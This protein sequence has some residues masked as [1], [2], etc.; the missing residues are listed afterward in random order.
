M[1]KQIILFFFLTMCGF[2][3]SYS[4]TISDS[5]SAEPQ[6]SFSISGNVDMYYRYGKNKT[7]SKTIPSY[8][9]G[10]NLGW[11]N[12]T[13]NKKWK[14]VDLVVD[15]VAGPRADQFYKKEDQE[16]V[17]T[18]IKQGYISYEPIKKL[19]LY[20]GSMTTPFNIE[21]LE[22]ATNFVYSNSYSNTIIAASFTGLKAEYVFNDTW[23]TSVGVY[24]DPDKK[25][26]PNPKKHIMG[27]LIY[28]GD[29]LSATADILNGRDGDTTAVFMADLYGFY[30]V[31]PAIKLGYQFHYMRDKPDRTKQVSEWFSTVIYAQYIIKNNLSIGTFIER[32]WDKDGY[33]FGSPDNHIWCFT[34]GCKYKVAQ[35][36]TLL[37]ELRMDTAD[38]PSFEHVS[39]GRVKTEQSFIIVGLYEF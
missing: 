6:A 19:K 30:K 13:M 24:S 32:F 27:T 12:L 26:D 20:A 18:Y 37:P 7:S 36:L 9:H 39:N 8:D 35:G 34:L 1:V 11:I 38:N 14:K 17:F 25:I 28:S 22:P 3:M 5:I 23:T 31:N 4:Q 29:K 21:Y 15:L 10:I 16:N 33:Y 2:T